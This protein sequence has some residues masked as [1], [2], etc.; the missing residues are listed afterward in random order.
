[1]YDLYFYNAKVVRVV[2]GD[3]LIL[4]VDLGFNI[5]LTER[6]R[7]AGINCK[8]LNTKDGLRAK[9]FVEEYLAKNNNECLIK[10]EKKGKYGRWL[11]WV[12]VGNVCLNKLLVRRG[13]A[14]E[15]D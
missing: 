10:S 6:F 8:E 11:A 2:D 13:F 7:L 15:Y 5:K 4:E 12:W 1:M 9:K 3:T 14:E